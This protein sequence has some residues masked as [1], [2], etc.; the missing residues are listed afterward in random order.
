MWKFEQNDS[1][2]NKRMKVGGS[3]FE[4][5]GFKAEAEASSVGGN[6]SSEQSNKPCEAPKPDYIHVRARRGQA[7]DSHSLAERVTR[8]SLSLS[9]SFCFLFSCKFCLLLGIFFLP[10]K[11]M[12]SIGTFRPFLL[13]L[14]IYYLFTGM[15]LNCTSFGR[16]EEKR[17]VRG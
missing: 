11:Q 6:K 1:G 4:N 17:S 7:T 15:P 14:Y 12:K 5:D 9:L 13:V 10:Q 16:Q 2:S 8:F 3:S